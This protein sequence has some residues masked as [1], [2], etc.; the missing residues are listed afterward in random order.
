MSEHTFSRRKFFART[1]AGVA[2]FG[3][4]ALIARRAYGAN[5][6]LSIGLIGVGDRCSAHMADIRSLA[7]KQNVEITAVCDVWKA[8]LGRA[9]ARI[10]DGLGKE[11]RQFARFGDL[12]AL[13][14]IDAVVIATPD[15]SHGPILIAALKAGK[16]VYVEKPMCMELADA[17]T[18]LDLARST[19]RVVQAGTQYRSHGGYIAASKVLAAGVLG[20]INRVCAEANF[21]EPRWARS[22]ADCKKDDVDWDAYL[23]DKPRRDFDPK[24]LRRW[25]LYKEFTNGLSGLWMSHYADAVH[26]LTGAKYPASAV[27][28]GNIYVWKDGREHTDTFHALLDYPEG[29][30]M[31]WGFGLANSAG[32]HFAAYGTE[33]MLEIGNDHVEPNLLTISAAGGRKDSKV[34]GKKIVAEPSQSH[35]ANWLECI[36]SRKRPNAD[37]QYGHQHSVATIL[38]ADALHKGRRMRY[39]PEKRMI[40]EG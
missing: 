2:A 28:H 3:A 32:C 16:D 5:E 30:L 21:N 38:A 22:F 26:L 8:N 36:R 17:N 9:A 34:E 25:H 27:A 12:L 31:S 39:D 40:S 11:P 18:A 19:G 20:R 35:M 24:L 33:G 4:T 10:K 1:S 14:D 15:F 23:L 6:R 29:F 7:E 13:A 37:I